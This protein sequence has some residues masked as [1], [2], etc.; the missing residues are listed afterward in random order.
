M[1]GWNSGRNNR[2][3]GRCE[4]WHR[5]ELPGLGSETAAAMTR[6]RAVR[7]ILDIVWG[8]PVAGRVIYEV[9]EAP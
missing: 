4:S 9:D 7:L 6:V 2:G 8:G 1:G 3:A 5:L